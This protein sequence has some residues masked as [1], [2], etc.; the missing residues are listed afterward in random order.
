MLAKVALE[1]SPIH[2]ELRLGSCWSELMNQF[3]ARL[4]ECLR[5]I[6]CVRERF[7]NGLSLG[8][9]LRVKRRRDDESAFFGRFQGEDE[10]TITHRIALWFG[11]R[12]PG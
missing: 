6:A 8:H 10:L 5:R 9:K 3:L 12:L 7:G 11:H 4:V 1:I 2:G